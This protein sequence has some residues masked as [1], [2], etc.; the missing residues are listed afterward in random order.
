M[1]GDGVEAA[2]RDVAVAGGG[3]FTVTDR[4]GAGLCLGAGAGVGSGA[5][6]G[7]LTG[8]VL[9]GGAQHLQQCSSS[10]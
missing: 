4:A 10:P 2:G 9:G 7:G 8:G 3:G 1:P 5:V 6:V